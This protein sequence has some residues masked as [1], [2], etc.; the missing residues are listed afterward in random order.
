MKRRALTVIKPIAILIAVGLIYLIIYC[1]TGF[2][3]PCLI[4]SVFHVYCGSCGVT[5]MLVY[6][7][8]FQFYEAFSSNCLLMCMLPL[9]VFFY[10][11][12]S[13][14]YIRYGKHG[15]ERWEKI[16]LWVAVVSILIF[17]VIR[18]LYPIDIL[19]P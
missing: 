18:N 12:H 4:Y 17:A 5:R 1:S 11:R 9:L 16:V 8:K 2:S 19:I 15:L 10:V 13:Y 14:I 7:S 3:I 6:L